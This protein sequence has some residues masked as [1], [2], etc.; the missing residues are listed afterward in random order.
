[1][2]I[3]LYLKNGV[4]TTKLGT[5]IMHLKPKTKEDK[6]IFPKK[7]CVLHL[8]CR[9]SLVKLVSKESAFP[10]QC[11]TKQIKFEGSN[12]LKWASIAP[13]ESCVTYLP[14]D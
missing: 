5:I 10:V 7:L 13:T 4:L 1:M 12:F 2:M 9:N 14:S 6:K 8:V 3:S 11:R